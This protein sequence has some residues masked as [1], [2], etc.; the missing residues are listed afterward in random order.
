MLIV[1]ESKIRR[2]SRKTKANLAQVISTQAGI[3]QAS[4][5]DL[6]S[7]VFLFFV[8][9]PIVGYSGNSEWVLETVATYHVCPNRDWFSTFEK[10]D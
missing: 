1:Q 9:T 10:L 5:S 7:S 8:T 2:R 6:D 3:S 4:G